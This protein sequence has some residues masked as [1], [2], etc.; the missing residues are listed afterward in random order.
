MS[1]FSSDP[2]TSE[3]PS[4]KGKP[5]LWAEG[6]QR[7]GFDLRAFLSVSLANSR[8]FAS[9]LLAAS[10]ARLDH[11]GARVETGEIRIPEARL[12][13]SGVLLPSHAAMGR[14]LRDTAALV[15][16]ASHSAL[17][18]PP[19][20]PMPFRGW[21][22]TMPE[23]DV[24]PP[25]RM[26]VT[27]IPVVE[28]IATAALP[29]AEKPAAQR[30]KRPSSPPAPPTGRAEGDRDTLEA[31]RSLMHSAMIEPV[32]PV[33]APRAPPP[34]PPLPT[35]VQALPDLEPPEPVPPGPLFNFAGQ[36]LGASAV[37]LAYP[38]GM[39]QAGVAIVRGED[40][41]LQL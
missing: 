4:I 17:G 15:L 9:P 11:F 32:H 33:R 5:K 19:V 27:P 7:P 41:R 18:A 39:V 20:E 21:D 36:A 1:S 10:A 40:L 22:G 35:G 34:P 23:T 25:P 26:P 16:A 8:S 13:R 29:L 37:A 6:R 28:D 2:G 14:R 38:I 24:V 31:I 30:P 3:K 12:G